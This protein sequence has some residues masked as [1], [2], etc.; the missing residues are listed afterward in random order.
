MLTAFC[1][2]NSVIY[3]PE[4]SR[5]TENLRLVTF[6]V[7]LSGHQVLPSVNGSKDGYARVSWRVNEFTRQT[8]TVESQ[9]VLACLTSPPTPITHRTSWGATG[10]RGTYRSRS[11]LFRDGRRLERPKVLIISSS[12]SFPPNLPSTQF[13]LICWKRF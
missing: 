11:A 12:P 5:V 1:S 10:T 9:P 3:H 13:S 7:T 6:E 8:G 4:I 2:Y